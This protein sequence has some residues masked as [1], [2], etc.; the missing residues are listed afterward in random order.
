MDKI[1]FWLSEYETRFKTFWSYRNSGYLETEILS[2]SQKRVTKNENTI[3]R[4]PEARSST[5]IFTILYNFVSKIPFENDNM[6]YVLFLL[7]A[8][9]QGTEQNWRQRS[10]TMMN[11]FSGYQKFEQV[12]GTWESVDWNWIANR[13]CK[14]ASIINESLIKK[15]AL[16]S[17]SIFAN[18]GFVF[19]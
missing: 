17:H 3:R 4:I 13:W 8:T 16:P 5:S 14:T 15:N 11:I 1:E 19:R 10:L 6:R 9:C 2:G 18:Y 7:K 12:V